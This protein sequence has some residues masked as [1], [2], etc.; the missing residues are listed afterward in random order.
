VDA[1]FNRGI[2][3]YII[4]DI[5]RAKKKKGSKKGKE[6]RKKEKK[7]G[8][9]CKKKGGGC[10][11]RGCATGSIPASLS[12]CANSEAPSGCT[13]ETPP[14]GPG[15]CCHPQAP[16]TWKVENVVFKSRN[17]NELGPRPSS[18]VLSAAQG[19]LCFRSLLCCW[20]DIL[21]D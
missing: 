16:D 5:N 13:A 4:N 17:F 1:V 7:K 14:R 8:K 9:Q 18:Y 19:V 15:S 6:K 11:G 10:K 2:S 3:A 12:P 21:G 20:D